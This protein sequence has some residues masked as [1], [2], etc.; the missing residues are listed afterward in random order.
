[1]TYIVKR[2][3]NIV[4]FDKQKIINAI[5]K[6]FLEIDGEIYETDTARDIA[7]DISKKVISNKT[8]VEEI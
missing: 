1:M 8:N 7:E 5:N 2:D 6:A 3:K 4:E